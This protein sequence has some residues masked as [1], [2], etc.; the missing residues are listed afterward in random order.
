[1]SIED[2]INRYQQTNTLT[3]AEAKEVCEEPLRQLLFDYFK[4]HKNRNFALALLNR[5]IELRKDPDN[6]V[7]GDDL[8]LACYILG[9]HKQVEDC[10]LIWKAKR[11][12]FD[13]Y[14][15][16]DGQLIAFMGAQPT[17]DFL[18]TVNSEEA[19]DA[20]FYTTGCV[21]SGDYDSLDEYYSRNSYYWL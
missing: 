4:T 16:I 15:Y 18:K 1:M 2:F 9:Q 12:D 13:S 10:L 14:C 5:L 21:E 7:S 3:A 6:L 17:I 20:L 11:T 8:M 19:A